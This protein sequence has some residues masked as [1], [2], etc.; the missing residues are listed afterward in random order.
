MTS[1]YTK[2]G[3]VH[4][5]WKYRMQSLYFQTLCD[6]TEHIEMFYS[7]IL[8]NV[9]SRFQKNSSTLKSKYKV[10]KL[11]IWGLLQLLGWKYYMAIKDQF[12][13]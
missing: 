2:T 5:H 12:V 1:E 3:P 4:E 11:K 8:K 9:L 13:W 10:V 6:Y 7:N